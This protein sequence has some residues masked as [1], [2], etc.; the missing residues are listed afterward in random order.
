[1]KRGNDK[2][3]PSVWKKTKFESH[4]AAVP[5][6]NL[7][8]NWQKQPD[9]LTESAKYSHNVETIVLSSDDEEDLNARKVI[10]AQSLKRPSIAQQKITTDTTKKQIAEDTKDSNEKA[11]N[12]YVDLSKQESQKRKDNAK[13][14]ESITSGSD[15]NT[16]TKP[17][18]KTEKG[19]PSPSA[20]AANQD[21]HTATSIKSIKLFFPSKEKDIEV[22]NEEAATEEDVIVDDII[23]SPIQSVASHSSSTVRSDTSLSSEEEIDEIESNDS[24][25]EDDIST[26]KENIP[27]KQTND[28]DD[29]EHTAELALVAQKQARSRES[30]KKP[31]TLI[32]QVF[33]KRHSAR[34]SSKKVVSY[35]DI[36]NSIDLTID[37]DSA[38][39]LP[40]TSSR[41]PRIPRAS[42][43]SPRTI[44][45]QTQFPAVVAPMAL[46]K[47]RSLKT[48]FV[49]DTVM[50]Y[51]ATP[52]P[53]EIHPEDPRRI[54]KIFNILD[55]HGLLK[56]CLRIQSRRATKE[57]ILLVHNIVH[58]RKLRD[59]SGKSNQC[60]KVPLSEL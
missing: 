44:S 25:Q 6:S 50:S 35:N 32:Q 55:R 33:T 28:T 30:S 13:T 17:E 40:V 23:T 38:S 5:P 27:E 41:S 10:L 18:I 51:H 24:D 52:D 14:N 57:E 22:K 60:I 15:S 26:K 31:L 2:V 53:M 45:N 21:S 46:T 3:E 39:H 9:D 58:F 20:G 12:Q 16:I 19:A 42:S 54:F 8:A 11:N 37:E 34:E 29:V 4:I 49:Y 47:H 7:A 59:T 43:S 36:T 48:G 56:E 1:M